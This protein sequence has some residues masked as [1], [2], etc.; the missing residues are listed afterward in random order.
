MIVTNTNIVRVVA[1]ALTSPVALGL[2]A[3]ITPSLPNT[4]Q[5]WQSRDQ[6]QNA[7]ALAA[8]PTPVDIPPYNASIEPIKIVE[9]VETVRIDHPEDPDFIAW[10]LDRD[11]ALCRSLL[12]FAR[13]LWGFITL[14][15]VQTACSVLAWLYQARVSKQRLQAKERAFTRRLQAKQTTIA[16]LRWRLAVKAALFADARKCPKIVDAETQADLVEFPAP[17]RP[18]FVAEQST[19]TESEVADTPSVSGLTTPPTSPQLPPPRLAYFDD[20]IANCWP[21]SPDSTQ[22]ET[23]KELLACD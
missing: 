22:S 7:H 2:F 17:E 21:D 13:A 3:W 19:D 15:L 8:L 11:S 14:P 9:A 10:Q 6:N 16:K 1:L 5:T 4:P 18:S 12:R 20:I 23:L